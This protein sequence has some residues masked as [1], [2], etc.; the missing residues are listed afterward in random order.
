LLSGLH[1]MM[2]FPRKVGGILE[3]AFG[4]GNSCPAQQRTAVGVFVGP[5]V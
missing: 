5:V 4:E 1:E 3:G 2:G